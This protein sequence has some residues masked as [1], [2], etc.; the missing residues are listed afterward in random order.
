M[1]QRSTVE[2]SGLIDFV[3][4]SP[5]PYHA[6]AAARARLIGAGFSEVAE[7]ASWPAGGS[8]LVVR[9]GTVIAWHVPEGVSA[10]AGMRLIGAH[11]DS[12]NLRVRPRPERSHLGYRQLGIDVYG[13]AL[14]NSWL[15][16]DLGVSGR[17][18]VQCAGRSEVRLLRVDLPWL[19]VAQLAPHLDGHRADG[20]QINPQT[21][22]VPILGLEST[23]EYTF[24]SL[25]AGELGLDPGEI[26]SWDL[27]AHD[28]TPGSLSG[29]GNEFISSARLDNLGSCYS[30]TRAMV[31]HVKGGSREDG[32][33]VICLFDH[34][35]VGSATSS[36]AAGALLPSVLERVVISLGGGREDF[37]RA[38]AGST[39]VSADMAHAVHPN[40]E[41]YYE[42]EHLL[43]V[44]RGPAIKRNSGQRYATDALG[45]AAFI[46][47]CERAQVPFQIYV[48]RADKPCGSTIGPMLSARL[49]VSTVDVGM[50]QLAMHS[51]RE[52][53]GA[54][55]VSHMVTALASFLD[56]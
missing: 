2:A 17:V 12:P 8:H 6:V 32:I 28:L 5:S 4:A 36:G 41:E 46:G 23:G 33:A 7:S 48:N 44:N 24:T 22:L 9:G 1:A 51:A 30:A 19:R 50:G 29:A 21:Q 16:R 27:M 49:G 42:P 34:E 38:L 56:G 3:D 18:V 14:T 45:E 55:D 54:E 52:L 37:L 26:T 10:G 13:G 11:T 31:E 39:L 47:A 35:E 20:L 25:V 15:D 53:C 43:Y 40:Y